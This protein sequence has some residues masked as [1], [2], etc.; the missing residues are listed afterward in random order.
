MGWGTLATTEVIDRLVTSVWG[1]DK[2]G[3][4]HFS[5]TF[6]PPIYFI[7]FN[8]G[9]QEVYNRHFVGKEIYFEHFLVTH[10][11][12]SHREMLARAVTKYLEALKLGEQNGGSVVVDLASELW[13]LIQSVKLEDVKARKAKAKGIEAE[14]VQVHQFDY[15]QANL[16]MAGLMKQAL[17]TPHVN[18]CLLSDSSARY[19]EKGNDTG[20][21]KFHGW[22]PMRGIVPVTLRAMEPGKILI[23]RNRFD[24]TLEGT[25]VKDADYERVRAI[26]L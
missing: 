1:E 18:V 7:N 22:N 17:A 11:P 5:M 26:I 12:G 10:D 25:T 9:Y 13:T 23:D 24:T 3:K 14:D 21:V 6:P 4:T 2:K 16:F 8:Y 15:G 19:N 20:Q